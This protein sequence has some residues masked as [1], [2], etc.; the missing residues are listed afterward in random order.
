MDHEISAVPSVGCGDPSVAETLIDPW[1]LARIACPWDHQSLT[2][3]GTLLACRC[4]REFPVIRGVPVLLRDDV[5]GNHSTFASALAVARGEAPV[6]EL[7]HSS[8]AVHPWVQVWIAATNGLMYASVIG[9][10]REYPIPNLRALPD[11]D[12]R[13]LLDLGCNWGRWCIAAGRRGYRPIGLDPSLEGVLAGQVIARQFG[14]PTW[15]VVGDARHLPFRDRAVDVAY[16]YSVL[17]HFSREDVHRTLLDT[18]RVV[19]PNGDVWVQMPNRYGIRSLY[20]LTRRGFRDGHDFEVRYWTAAELR[21]QFS[22]A[23]GPTTLAIDGFFSV[24]AQPSEAHLLPLRFQAVVKTSEQ[25]R[26][27]GEHFPL[28]QSVADSLMVHAVNAP[29]S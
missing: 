29:H 13:V 19:V 22:D 8:E 1:L 18:S 25:L 23:V 2:V 15:F 4:G 6:P 27:F 28:L 11:G 24:N 17:Q 3:S 7:P 16:S 5:P 26:K 10:L 9:K 12:G 14:I 20:H 21:K